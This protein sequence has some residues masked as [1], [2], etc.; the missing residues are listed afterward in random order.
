LRSTFKKIQNGMKTD[1]N[2]S[3]D[4]IGRLEEIGFQLQGAAYN[5]A[6][7]KHCHELVAFKK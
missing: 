1:S 4:R 3:Q 5:E 2:L 7:E 6:F